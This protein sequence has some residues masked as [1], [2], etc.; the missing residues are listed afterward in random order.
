MVVCFTTY[1]QLPLT[2]NP[3]HRG[4]I[5]LLTR[6]IGMANGTLPAKSNPATQESIVCHPPVSYRVETAIMPTN[7]TDSRKPVIV[8]GEG[9]SPHKPTEGMPTFGTMRPGVSF[10]NIVAQHAPAAKKDDGKTIVS[11]VA[12][13]GGGTSLKFGSFNASLPMRVQSAPPQLEEQEQVAPASLGA[14][15][16]TPE[17][18]PAQFSGHNQGSSV[19]APL[20][21]N[22]RPFVPTG[23]ARPFYP[24]GGPAYYGNGMNYAP[25]PPMAYYAPR[26]Y[27]N[28]YPQQAYYQ[29]GNSTYRPYQ[30]YQSHPVQPQTTAPVQENAPSAPTPSV[31]IT[32]PP[33]PAAVPRQTKKIAIV[34]PT[35]GQEIEIGAVPKLSKPADKTIVKIEP[36]SQQVPSTAAASDV[37]ESPRKT[38]VLVDPRSNQA[39]DIA[40]LAAG[41]ILPTPM[42][43][44]DEED[45]FAG[46]VTDA[47]EEESEEGEEDAFPTDLQFPVILTRAIKVSYPEGSIKFAF[48]EEGEP[49][50]YSSEF[51][52]QFADHCQGDAQ[53]IASVA[54]PKDIPERPSTS[55]RGGGRSGRGGRGSTSTRRYT[56]AE[57]VLSNRAEDAWKR[58]N[59]MALD[60]DLVLLREM[61]QILNKLTEEKFEKLTDQILEMSILKPAVMTGVIDM[62]FDKA[63]EEPRYAPLYA[64]LCLSIARHEV[65]QQKKDLSAEEQEKANSIF[66]KHLV[67]K[68]Q[69][70]YQAKRAYTSQRLE[71]LMAKAMAEAGESEESVEES[72]EKKGETKPTTVS[73]ELTEDDYAMIKTKR[74]VL[75]NMKFIGELYMVGLI[76]PKIMH[77]VIQELLTD[78]VNPEEEEVESVCR[79]IP[80]IGAM[81]DTPESSSYWAKYIERLRGLSV[82]TKLPTRVRF[83]LQDLLELRANGWKK[84]KPAPLRREPREEIRN[85]RHERGDN[86]R[87]SGNVRRYTTGPRGGDARTQDVRFE[88]SG[89]SR[90]QARTTTASDDQIPRPP[91]AISRTSQ[92]SLNRYQALEAEE[93][94]VEGVPTPTSTPADSDVS[95][96]QLDEK[97]LSKLTAVFSESQSQKNY[98]D[99]KEIVE[100]IALPYRGSALKALVLYSMDKGRK[101]VNSLL[102]DVLPLLFASGDDLL[103]STVVCSGLSESF[104]MLDDLVVDIPNAIEFAGLFSAAFL[105]A[106]KFN[107]ATLVESILASVFERDSLMAAKVV[108]YALHASRREDKRA[109]IEESKEVLDKCVYE[110]T[111][112]SSVHTLATKLELVD[113]LQL[114]A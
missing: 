10:K 32:A 9:V 85:E 7:N 59:D 22:A 46:G 49:L 40:K 11:E 45:V 8:A 62:L 108:L 3:A 2:L 17:G 44:V 26:P 70:E 50:R 73:G 52:L 30:N 15:E 114:S 1:Q 56:A 81:L 98:S 25:Y 57:T 106:Q 99:V 88:K 18:V 65:E 110:P 54:F 20:P 27:G 64:R 97:I 112:S 86:R 100:E 101:H 38:V 41:E 55:K 68:C 109:L 82:N 94:T 60:E 93:A 29:P 75:G 113:L 5:V 12:V 21:E 103:P 33:A 48:P 23:E 58:A 42:D 14:L 28:Y 83:M 89:S 35:T 51:L 77:T 96:S 16:A 102:V 90:S 36:P 105:D 87:G 74:R 69:I 67:T 79:L 43:E 66:R 104:E 37:A 72:S 6:V 76:P 78:I 92:E 13:P 71:M 24:Q 107:L 31:T 4:Q 84:A 91:S 61:K 53:D 19:A 95:T 47:S 80:T 39:V 34:D 63:V 111:N